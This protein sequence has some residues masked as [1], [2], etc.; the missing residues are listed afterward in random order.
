[1]IISKQTNSSPYIDLDFYLNQFI[2]SGNCFN[3]SERI[4]DKLIHLFNEDLQIYSIEPLKFTFALVYIN[5]MT[6]G[7]ICKFFETLVKLR[8]KQD[9]T[10][11]IKW[12]YVEEDEDMSELPDIIMA[13]TNI[14]INKI[15]T[16]QNEIDSISK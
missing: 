6:R 3:S 5:S 13:N 9:L 2:I 15:I 10:L 1:M 14:V 12:L 4:F 8:D 16:T 11:D 7:A